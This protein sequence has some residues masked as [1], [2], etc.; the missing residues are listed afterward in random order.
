[1]NEIL[2]FIRE[3][4]AIILPA[5]IALVIIYTILIIIWSVRMR[6]LFRRYEI[7]MSGKDAESLEDSIAELIDRVD[8]LKDEDTANK[9]AI[10]TLGRSI[11]RS[12]QRT[13]VVK[14][15]AF[16]GMGG[17]TSFVLTLLDGSGD[18]VI[19]NVIH[20]RETCYTYLKE[21]TDGV[22]EVELSNEEK[23]SLTLALQKK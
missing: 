10:R 16:D 22:S 8:D 7:F 13:G 20:S 4:T 23:A 6:K 17:K 21:V 19:V 2:N 18:G 12:V 9:D 1:M 11:G 15:N 3:N 5:L 14:Y